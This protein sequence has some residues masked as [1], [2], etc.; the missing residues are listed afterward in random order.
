MNVTKYIVRAGVVSAL[1]ASLTIAFAFSSFSTATIQ[2]RVSEV[3]T[4]L[5][6][7]F[8]ETTIALWIGCILGNI[9]GGN[10]LDIFIGSSATLIA[11]LLTLLIGRLF[12]RPV[13]RIIFGIIPPILVNAFIVPISFTLLIGAGVEVYLL[14]VLWVFIGQAITLT[15]GGVPFALAISTRFYR[16]GGEVMKEKRNDKGQTLAE[17][18]A[19]YDPSN[20]RHPS[21]TA[22][23]VVF[24]GDKVLLVRRGNHPD[25]GALAFPG[26]FCEE[27][28]ST[29]QTATR[30]LFEETGAKNVPCRQ[31]Y[32]ASAPGR[33]PRDWTITVCYIAELS[34]E[35][36][37]KGNDDASSAEFYA[38]SITQVGELTKLTLVGSDGKEE[39]TLR[40]KRDSF[41]K[42]DVNATEIV[43]NGM[44]FDHAKILLRAI[45]ERSSIN[46][47][48]L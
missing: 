29:E 26:G 11:S 14:Q 22:D 27:G 17:F 8:P 47:L 41:G 1:Y 32:T 5:P 35:I 43:K 45:E 40:V 20:W 44:A 16:A 4:V 9:I 3:L 2:I 10:V 25:I 24:S 36:A 6:L 12:R 13:L 23:C 34:S 19:E 33:D 38:Y 46:V 18:L 39:C 15:A 30:E 48:S 28:E 31:F 42:V 21:V 7:F 37:V